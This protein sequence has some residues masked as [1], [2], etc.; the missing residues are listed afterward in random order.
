MKSEE[1]SKVKKSGGKRIVRFN[2]KQSKES[3][4]KA[5]RAVQSIHTPNQ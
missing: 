4:L 5:M 3:R 1:K 2:T